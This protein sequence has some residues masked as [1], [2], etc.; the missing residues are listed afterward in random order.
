SS[1]CSSLSGRI[2][3]IIP[4]TNLKCSL[5][6]VISEKPTLTPASRTEN[7]NPPGSVMPSGTTPPS[8]FPIAEVGKVFSLYPTAVD[9]V[10]APESQVIG[11]C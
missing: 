6:L 4:L 1:S 10:L 8:P 2:S 7:V 11:I 5:H 9:E 3:D